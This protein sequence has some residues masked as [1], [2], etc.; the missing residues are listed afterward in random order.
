VVPPGGVLRRA[1][2]MIVMRGINVFPSAIENIV[3]KCGEIIEFEVLVEKRREMAELLISIEVR[4]G[5]AE[6]L[7]RALAERVFGRLNLRPELHV[8]V[9]PSLPRYEL[10]ALRFKNRI[11]QVQ[12]RSHGCRVGA[13]L[14][15]SFSFFALD[16]K[17][18]RAEKQGGNEEKHASGERWNPVDQKVHCNRLLPSASRMIPRYTKINPHVTPTT[19]S[20]ALGEAA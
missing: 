2:D 18:V 3:R 7:G 17:V 14:A 10:K 13:T 16:A 5:S 12:H 15:W 9:P 6:A 1:D 19:S 11:R 20:A 8:V 4:D